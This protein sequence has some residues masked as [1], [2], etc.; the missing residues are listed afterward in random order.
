MSFP[1]LRFDNR[2]LE[3]LPVDKSRLAGTRRV[4]G[5]IF[6]LVDPTPVLGPVR[7][8][9]SSGPALALVGLGLST[10]VEGGAAAG[11]LEDYIDSNPALLEAFAGTEHIPHL[12]GFIINDICQRMRK[13]N[14]ILPGSSPAAHCY[15]GHQF[16]SFAGQL[17]DG[18]AIVSN[19]HLFYSSSILV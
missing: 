8:V 2:N 7:L 18:A 4:P 6:S 11:N 9:A 12:G 13:G 1:T 5:A 19:S 14:T 15:A 16:G 3:Q 17:G 10:A